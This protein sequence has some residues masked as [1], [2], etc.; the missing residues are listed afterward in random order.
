MKQEFNFARDGSKDLGQEVSRLKSQSVAIDKEF[1]VN[2][3]MIS[4]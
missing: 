2:N 3:A 4:K 1:N